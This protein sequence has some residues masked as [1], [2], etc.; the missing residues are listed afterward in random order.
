[1]VYVPNPVPCFLDGM[2]KYKVIGGRQ[3]YRTKDRY[4][5]CDEFHGEIEVYNKRGRHLGALDAVTGELIKEAERGR[6]I[7]V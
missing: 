5:Q 6:T 7:I 2:E 4:Y 1:M 3:T